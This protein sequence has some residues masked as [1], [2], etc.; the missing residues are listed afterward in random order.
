MHL[1]TLALYGFVTLGI[2]ICMLAAKTCAHVPENTA[3]ADAPTS[4]KPTLQGALPPPPID[5]QTG[6][7]MDEETVAPTMPAATADDR[8]LP[9]VCAQLDLLL[10]QPHPPAP[11][12]AEIDQGFEAMLM[13]YRRQTADQNTL[14]ARSTLAE[15]LACAP[16]ASASMVRVLRNDLA[17]RTHQGEQP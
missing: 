17:P 7:R 2:G 15:L 13:N 16:H 3:N 4:P 12:Q 9:P 5:P 6:L 8:E 1:G 14:G 11:N 10:A